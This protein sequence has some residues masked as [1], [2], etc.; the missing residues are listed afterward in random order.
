MMSRMSLTRRSF[1]VAGGLGVLGAG[2]A[3]VAMEYDVLPGRTRAYDLFG[4]NGSPGST[5]NVAG[6]PV[7]RG[8]IDGA[9]FVICRPP[10][11]TDRLP[12]VLALH[13]AFSSAAWAV[14]EFHL[15]RFL[16]ASGQQFAMA[17]IDGGD[18]YWHPR[19]DGSDKPA[20]IR[21]HFLPMLADRGYD[22]HRP[23][24]IGWSMGGYGALLMATELDRVG[25]VCG[26]SAALWKSYDETAPGSFDSQADFDE[27]NMFDRRDQLAG[28][29][30]RL[31]CGRGDPFFRNVADFAEL[32]DVE[33][34]A[35]AGAHD[36]GYWRRVLPDELSWLGA[37]LG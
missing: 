7:E 23:G 25:P 8:T 15:D 36:E 6:G 16:A 18:T 5:P 26:V 17:A 33:F 32:T 30:V 14:D 28:L 27:W 24:I 4:L 13:G 9:G 2:G 12:V 34:H 22:V 20:L 10:G 19:A 29:D 35:D 21:D 3:A 31:D 37:R 1:I 11:V